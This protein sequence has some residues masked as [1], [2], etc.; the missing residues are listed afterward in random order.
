MTDPVHGPA[1]R[2]PPDGAGSGASGREQS[3]N[4][5]QTS[6]PAHRRD[7]RLAALSLCSDGANVLLLPAAA[8]CS[9]LRRL[10]SA[11]PRSGEGLADA[12]RRA[13][14]GPLHVTPEVGGLRLLVELT[15]VDA[16]DAARC[17]NHPLHWVLAVF[18]CGL[19]TS[20]SLPG[21]A[22]WLPVHTLTGR[23]VL[24]TDLRFIGDA[25]RAGPYARYRRVHVRVQAGRLVVLRY[26]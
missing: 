13:V 19:P 23:D 6:G 10:P 3:G 5:P 11:E 14:A 25:L 24:E 18:L 8:P 2:F 15:M 17:E 20:G 4:R 9:G 21:G 7:P 12:C 1:R 22:G 26:A 16:A